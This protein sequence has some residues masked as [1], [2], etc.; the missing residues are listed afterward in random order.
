MQDP[1]DLNVL[2]QEDA[3]HEKRVFERQKMRFTKL[4]S[5]TSSN[6]F[7]NIEVLITT[8]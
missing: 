1:K 5:I 7:I 2:I 4:T 8:F 6:F 3:L